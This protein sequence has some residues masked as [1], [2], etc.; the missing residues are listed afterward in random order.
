MISEGKFDYRPNIRNKDELGDLARSFVTMAQRLKRLEEMYLDTSPLTRLPGGI[1]IENILNKRIAAKAS[2]AFC[3]MDIDNF[4]AYNDHYGYA[5]GNDII[6][7]TATIIS[8]AVARYGHDNDFIGTDDSATW[9]KTVL[10]GIDHANKVLPR[11][12]FQWQ[13]ENL[14]RY[15]RTGKLR[16]GKLG[17]SQASADLESFM[18]VFA[19][20]SVSTG[21][22]IC[23]QHSIILSTIYDPHQP[24]PM[25]ASSRFLYLSMR[26]GISIDKVCAPPNGELLFTSLKYFLASASPLET[27]QSQNCPVR[28]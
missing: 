9:N 15:L 24:G 27:S 6:Q 10:I 20:V 4:K 18:N 16:L 11:V 14:G 28:S 25:D 3:L 12:E 13:R 5:K 17:E 7:A 26:L 8:E 2:I 19:L 21:T 23:L 22:F 1:A